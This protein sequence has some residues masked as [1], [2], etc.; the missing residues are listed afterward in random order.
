MGGFPSGSIELRFEAFKVCFRLEILQNLFRVISSVGHPERVDVSPQEIFRLKI[1]EDQNVKLLSALWLENRERIVR[2]RILDPIQNLFVIFLI[3]ADRIQGNSE[4]DF[5]AADVSLAEAESEDD[6]LPFVDRSRLR[7]GAG[8][9]ESSKDREK[10][11]KM[12]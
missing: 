6:V 8:F 10:S 12:L 9:G 7:D 11:G 5:S 2:N 1:F 4:V 3:S